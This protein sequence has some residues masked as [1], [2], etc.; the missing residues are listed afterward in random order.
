MPRESPFSTWSRLAY[1]WG[2]FKPFQQFNRCAPFK[3]FKVSGKIKIK[4]LLKF[5][6]DRRRYLRWV[7]EA[8]KRF[9][10]RCSI[11]SGAQLYG[12]IW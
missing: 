6:R 10:R 11:T 8:K 4:F 3:P 9:G 1:Q 12:D 7:F 5:A 2:S